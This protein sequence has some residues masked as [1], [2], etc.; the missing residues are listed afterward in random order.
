MSNAATSTDPK[1][2]GPQF[3]KPSRGD[4]YAIVNARGTQQGS[5][6]HGWSGY[7][8]M[9][10]SVAVMLCGQT[11]FTPASTGMTGR[12]GRIAVAAEVTCK[13]CMKLI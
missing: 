6:T 11:A 8:V 2:T 7:S 10:N 5:R 4:A 13:A 9:G 1:F 12:D 3:V